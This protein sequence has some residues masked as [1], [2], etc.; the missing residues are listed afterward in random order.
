MAAVPVTMRRIRALDRR[1]VMRAV[2]GRHERVADVARRRLP[3]A[4][5][6][7][8]LDPPP[9]IAIEVASGSNVTVAV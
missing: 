6:A 5:I 3:R 4:V 9:Q 8:V 2:I 1:L 7:A